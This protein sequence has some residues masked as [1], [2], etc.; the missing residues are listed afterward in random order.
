MH[1]C[2]RGG[3]TLVDSFETIFQLVECKGTIELRWLGGVVIAHGFD[4]IADLNVVNDTV[5]VESS[6]ENLFRAFVELEGPN[7]IGYRSG[8]KGGVFC[9]GEVFFSVL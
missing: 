8:N 4:N 3:R 6:G 9:L 7:V 5:D 1:S 2:W